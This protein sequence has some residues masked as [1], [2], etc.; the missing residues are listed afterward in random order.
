[1][2]APAALTDAALGRRVL[3]PL[4]LGGRRARHLVE[5]NAFAYRRMWLMFVSG[6][7]EPLFYLL[8]VTVGIS[9]LAGKVAGPDGRLITYTAFVAPALM[10]SSAM[11]GAVM[12]GTFAVFFKLKF[13]KVYHA[14]LATPLEAQDVALG[15]I[16]WAV[17]RG[18]IYSTVF[19]LVM[20]MMGLVHS[21]W[22]LLAVPAAV[23]EAFAFAAVA[24]ASTTFMR[25][26]QDFDFVNLALMPMFL[27]S[28]TFYPLSVY[29]G[30]LRDLVR[31][32]PLY[33]A[34]ALI[35]GLDLGG[36]NWAMLG[37]A[38]YLGAMAVIGLSVASRRLGHLILK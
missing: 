5:R 18:G 15:E 26:W 36:V 6:F 2:T 30:A 4:G 28:A 20:A 38:A 13:A 23:L 12:D 29:P 22:A 21:P 9:K 27:F 7:F 25:S 33:Q 11:N 19:L 17:S 14:V 8:S 3:P 34:V 37:H 16:S 10:A 32:V 31:V 35:R 24:M 1:V